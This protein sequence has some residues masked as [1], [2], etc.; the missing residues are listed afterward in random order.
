MLAPMKTPKL[1][2]YDYTPKPYTGPS[3]EEV[4]ASRKQ[5][6][7]PAL[8]LYYQKPLMIVDGKGQFVFDEKGKR[9]GVNRASNMEVQRSPQLWRSSCD[10][11]ISLSWTLR[12]R[13]SGSRQ[14]VRGRCAEFDSI[15]NTR[16]G[17]RIYC[18]V[19]SRSWRNRCIPR[20]LSFARISTCARSGWHLH[21]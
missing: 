14:S 20:W 19:N 8:F 11:S 12:I 15:R 18:R 2:P 4:L 13:L 3:A 21:S 9:Y 5:F 1:P 17:G 10:C 16:P 7:N 6:L